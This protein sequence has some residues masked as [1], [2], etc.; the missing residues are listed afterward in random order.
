MKPSVDEAAVAGIDRCQ[1]RT[2]A[3]Q[4]DSMRSWRILIL[5]MLCFAL[6]FVDRQILNLLV[7]PIKHTMGL[8]DTQISLL[9]GIAFVSAYCIAAPV[10]GRLV[11]TTNRRNVLIVGVVG[12]SVATTLC[13]FANTFWQ[14]AI[15]RFGV[16]LFE[17]SVFPV[18]WSMIPDLFSPQRSTRAYS[19]FMLGS[20]LGSAVALLA[21]GL[22]VATAH[23]LAELAPA[24]ST[25]ESWQSA[26]LLVGV[27]GLLAA[28]AL[29]F[30]NEPPR[31]TGRQTEVENFSVGQSLEVLAANHRFYVCIF[32]AVGTMAL[33]NLSLPAWFP[34]FLSRVYHVPLQEV[35][36]LFG[37]ALLAGGISG[38]LVGP[39]LGGWLEH[40]APGRASLLVSIA[41][42][43]GM[44]V[45]S[46]ALPLA[47][48]PVA[49]ILLAA[50]I[51]FFNNVSVPLIGAVCQRATP[52]QMRGMVSSIY[53][54]TVQ[55]I[56]YAGGP[57]MVALATDRL[58]RNHEMVGHSLQLV[59]SIASALMMLMLWL[60]IKPYTQLVADDE[61]DAKDV[62][63]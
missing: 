53:T 26:F 16:G 12:W 42:G 30:L 45:F 33:V 60:C 38:L 27:P 32:L 46:L 54:L 43:A 14:L 13:A 44:L 51:I 8:S 48:N 58:F 55:S 59:C 5:L 15:A 9:Q 4:P 57:T 40:R 25:L 1:R 18:A 24:L 21:G 37:S 20:Q 10:F 31:M 61:E 47:P 3:L 63:V 29:V 35:G 41:A 49:A 39:A 62:A 17:A 6:A 2:R 19:I 34:A 52:A 22:I 23:N 36:F 56:G 11:D 28:I 50:G 7:D